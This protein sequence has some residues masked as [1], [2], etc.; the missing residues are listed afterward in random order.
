MSVDTSANAESATLTL[1]PRGAMVP[2]A[3]I[4]HG[5]LALLGTS[6]MVISL[7][8]SATSPYNGGAINGIISTLSYFTIWSNI[9]ALVVN[10]ILAFDPTRDGPGFRWIRMTALVMIVIT[11]LVYAIILA[12]DAN[13]CGWGVYTN[14]VFHYIV[15][16]AMLLGFI[17]FGPRPRFGWDLLP[18]MLVIPMI[19]LVYTLLH[20]L[21]TINAPGD[22]CSNTP[23][24]V[25]VNFYPYP[26][27]NVN[28]DGTGGPAPLIPGVEFGG[29]AGVVVNIIAIIVLGLIMASIFVG[30]DRALSRGKKPTSL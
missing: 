6:A 1:A 17:I 27:I 25:G 13:P 11:G 8:L 4:Y 7:W 16:W 23:L 9:V 26:F 10:W 20:G 15:P 14:L 24:Q 28:Y 2:V 19:W 22:R 30:L 29:Y 21:M 12:A 5:L 3:R 18:K